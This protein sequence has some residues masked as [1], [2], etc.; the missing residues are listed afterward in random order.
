[1]DSATLDI[2]HN[3]TSPSPFFCTTLIQSTGPRIVLIS[4]KAG[5]ETRK[6]S[7]LLKKLFKILQEVSNFSLLQN[8]PPLTGFLIKKHPVLTKRK[9]FRLI[10]VKSCYVLLPMLLVCISKV[11]QPRYIPGVAQRVPGS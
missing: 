9:T 5:G 11:K 4:T 10:N 2:I 8:T 7:E 1:M 6:C 3:Y